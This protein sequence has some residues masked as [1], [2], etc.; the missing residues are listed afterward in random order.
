MVNNK[1]KIKFNCGLKQENKYLLNHFLF[2][3][4][5][6]KINLSI[7]KG[8]PFIYAYINIYI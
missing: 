8:C 4:F 2:V 1:L 7:A 6:F 5:F 3:D